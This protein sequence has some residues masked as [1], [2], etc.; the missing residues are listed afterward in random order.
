MEG[1]FLGL[2][3]MGE[4]GWGAKAE[5]KGAVLIRCDRSRTDEMMGA[6]EAVISSLLATVLATKLTES[7]M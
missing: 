7:W 1:L 2:G 4:R 3:A 5:G 6:R